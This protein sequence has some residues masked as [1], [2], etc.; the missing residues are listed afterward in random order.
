MSDDVKWPDNPVYWR[1][2][3]GRNGPRAVCMQSFDEYDY[4]QSQFLTSVKYETK[5]EAE[6][7]LGRM[8]LAF[9]RFGR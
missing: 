7:D 2:Y 4:D 6:A 8:A 9:L 3:S 5:A 1:L